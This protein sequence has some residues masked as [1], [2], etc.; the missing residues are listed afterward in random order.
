MCTK[1]IEPNLSFGVKTSNP[2]YVLVHYERELLVKMV[3]EIFMVKYL[4][5]ILV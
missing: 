2:T 5:K 4:K 3:N 1:N